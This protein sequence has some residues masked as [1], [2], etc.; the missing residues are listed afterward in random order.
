MG[1]P[2]GRLA[3]GYLGQLSKRSLK[4]K[5]GELSE[6][7]PGALLVN[8][9]NPAGLVTEALSRHSPDVPTV[10]VCNVPITMKM[11]ILERLEK[12]QGLKID[13]QRA[14]LK[15]LGLNHLSWHYGFIVDGEDIWPQILEG[16]VE[17]INWAME[18]IWL[19]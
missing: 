4:S 13:P 5:G 1:P 14:E 9:T 8:F 17:E 12:R 10:G 3:K 6:L 11:G 2:L 15:T 7:A 18:Q 19:R 16:F